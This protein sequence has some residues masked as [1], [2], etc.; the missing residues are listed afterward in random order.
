MQRK[1][2]A[3]KNMRIV[4]K[5]ALGY[6]LLVI[7][8]IIVFGGY[9]Y[10]Q[11]YLD[12]MSEYSE[13]KQKLV[14]QAGEGFRSSLNKVESIH[15]LF[16]YNQQLI[17]Y[18]SGSYRT[19]LEHVYNYLKDIRPLFMYA[20]SRDNEISTI[21]LYK[22]LPKVYS[23]NGEL[24][25]LDQMD[26]KPLALLDRVKVDE[27]VWVSRNG[28]KV[29]E[30]P[31]LSYYQRVF[32]NSY[33]KPLAVLEIVT[34]DSLLRNFLKAVDINQNM[35]VMIEQGGETVFHSE[36]KAL[37]DEQTKGL[38][39]LAEGSDQGYAY[40]RKQRILVNSL[41]IP[42]LSMTFYFFSRMDEV[43]V[44]IRIK[45]VVLALILLVSLVV[46]TGIYYATASSLVRRILG[47]AKHM[48]QVDESKL[49]YYKTGTSNDE[50]EF[51]TRSYN[52][53]IQ[54]ID[55]LLNTVHKAEL[56][57][58][59][60]EYLVLQAQIKPHF[61][62]NTLESIRM[63]AEINN[64]QEVV[65]ATYTFGRL[66]RYTLNSEENET[67]LVHEIDNVRHYLEMHKLRM[68][69]RLHFSIQVLTNIDDIRSPR[70]ILQPLV[71]NCIQHGI[72]RSRK[73]GEIEI[74]VTRENS[75]LLIM[76]TDNGPGITEE[77][78]QLIRGVLGNELDRQAL[79]NENSGYGLYNVSERI[80]MFY[81]AQSSLLIDSHEG[82]GTMFT[83][84]LALTEE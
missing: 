22:T 1:A 15:A 48:R 28:A 14:I 41:S 30:L 36:G 18:L 33:T 78:M 59:E 82:E 42:E 74:M 8:P 12:V 51:L 32:N 69:D 47:L 2:V 52:S 10:N 44:D 37:D 50:I 53:L 19:E 62:Y 55:E 24:E 34:N 71:E 72:G 13:G 54:R 64:D 49:T 16:L 9:L 7:L 57:K 29:P 73:R 39:A 5:M 38:L 63:L 27:G 75:D 35:Q 84:R 23:V 45:V 70:F 58:K 26:E 61:L 11:F 79:Q 56:M 76:I 17:D 40:S 67:L 60:A 3:M 81:G 6:M 31:I 65:D 80:R 4:Q 20:Q 21:K 77:R 68:L 46:L 83:L 66:L 43:F 25:H